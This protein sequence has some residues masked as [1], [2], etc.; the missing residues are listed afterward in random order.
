MKNQIATLK[1]L[2]Q[3]MKEEKKQRDAHYSEQ[4]QLQEND[5]M[6]LYRMLDK[7]KEEEQALQN[8]ISTIKLKTE[9]VKKK[10][11]MLEKSNYDMTIRIEQYQREES[12]LKIQ[13]EVTERKLEE[14][15]L[16]NEAIIK[17]KQSELRLISD[18]MIQIREQMNVYEDQIEIYVRKI[19]DQKAEILTISESLQQ[20]KKVVEE[21]KV[22]L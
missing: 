7:A 5:K 21:L 8:E 12:E 16:C 22:M 1:T 2:I 18:E 3:E 20:Y 15:K 14:E 10:E 19:G 6:E 11:E 4:I 17:E 9:D 13:L